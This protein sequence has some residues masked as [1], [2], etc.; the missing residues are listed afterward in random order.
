MVGV[1]ALGAPSRRRSALSA[2]SAQRARELVQVSVA[3]LPNKAAVHIAR[4][5]RAPGDPH[6]EPL[7]KAWRAGEAAATWQGGSISLAHG[8]AGVVGLARRTL[9]RCGEGGGAGPP[10]RVTGDTLRSK[11]P[12]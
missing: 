4:A 3:W 5:V 12:S 10:R 9:R 1:G 2:H 7:L 8:Q 11:W 6:Q